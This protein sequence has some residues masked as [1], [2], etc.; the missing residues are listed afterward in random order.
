M[1]RLEISLYFPN[2]GSFG[3]KI[4]SFGFVTDSDD[5]NTKSVDT[6]DDVDNYADGGK[7]DEADDEKESSM[8]TDDNAEDSDKQEDDDSNDDSYDESKFKLLLW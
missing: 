7:D 3:K 6:G 8:Q 4:K 5:E 2:G 1:W